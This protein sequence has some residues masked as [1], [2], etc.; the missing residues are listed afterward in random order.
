MRSRA[1]LL[2][3]SLGLAG[4]LALAGCGGGGGAQL[5]IAGLYVGVMEGD[6]DGPLRFQVLSDGRLEGNFR[7]PP[8]CGGPVHIT[9]KVTEDGI[10]TF[11]GHACGITF[12][13]TGRV[14]LDWDGISTLQGSGTWTGDDGSDGTWSVTRTGST[15]SISV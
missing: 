11:R 6:G 7:L 13:G 14:Q 2:A 9:G 12:T 4:I 10:V 8:V 3:G 15:G 5:T 1:T